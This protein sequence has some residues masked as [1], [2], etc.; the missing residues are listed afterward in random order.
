MRTGNF[1]GPDATSAQIATTRVP[2]SSRYPSGLV[3]MRASAAGTGAR[4]EKV[5]AGWFPP[6]RHIFRLRSPSIFAQTAQ[7]PIR[8]R[9][10][11][12]RH[13][14]RG[15][16]ASVANGASPPKVYLCALLCRGVRLSVGRPARVRVARASRIW[17]DDAL[18]NDH[19]GGVDGAGESD[20]ETLSII[21]DVGGWRVAGKGAADDPNQRNRAALETTFDESAP[22]SRSVRF[23]VVA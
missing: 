22:I 21:G 9:P 13:R 15:K 8:S 2:V 11:G 20:R 23:K 4:P 6:R 1:D 10:F 17:A 19:L 18:R 12:T 14:W 16:N 3:A 7:T 5:M